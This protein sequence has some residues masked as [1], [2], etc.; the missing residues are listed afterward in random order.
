MHKVLAGVLIL[1]AGMSLIAYMLIPKESNDARTPL[2][3]TTD[4]NPQREPQVEWFNKAYPD[5]KLR[6]DP[7]NSDTMKVIVQ[8]CAGMG[9]DIVGRISGGAI[10]N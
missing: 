1:L 4:P 10:Q 6:I 8:S 9:P 3:W 5:C 2:V 7:D